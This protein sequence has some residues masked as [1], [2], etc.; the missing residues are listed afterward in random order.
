MIESVAALGLLD[1]EA[2]LESQVLGSGCFKVYWAAGCR[3]DRAQSR[4]L[5]IG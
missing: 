3:S 5:I 2:G 1:A 4:T